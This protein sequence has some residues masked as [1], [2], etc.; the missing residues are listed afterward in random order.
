[1]T[2]ARRDRSY[3]VIDHVVF[4]AVNFGKGRR[5]D[6][7]ARAVGGLL[8]YLRSRGLKVER[9]ETPTAWETYK[10]TGILW[11]WRVGGSGF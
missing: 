6:V 7:Q 8:F 2:T 1:M 10:E 9:R 3:G 4:I 11:G 5:E